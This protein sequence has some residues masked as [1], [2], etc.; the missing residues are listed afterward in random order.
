[1]SSNLP[2][3][4]P[5]YASAVGLLVACFITLLACATGNE[6]HTVLSRAALGGIASG[7]F[8]RAIMIASRQLFHDD[9][10]PL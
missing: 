3:V 8:F 1:M 4:S 10:R 9:D 5:P 6:P 2:S 7:L